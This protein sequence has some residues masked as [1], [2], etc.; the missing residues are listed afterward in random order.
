MATHWN[1]PF[2]GRDFHSLK[3]DTSYTTHAAHVVS[4]S[5]QSFTHWRGR[6]RRRLHDGHLD[7]DLSAISHAD[8]FA[9]F[10][11][12]AVDLTV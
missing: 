7:L 5:H 6:G 4:S 2:D 11:G 1:N 10:S 3:T 12:F 9:E 8:V